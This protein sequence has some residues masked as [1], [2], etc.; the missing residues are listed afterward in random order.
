MGSGI[1]D[2]RFQQDCDV[3][4]SQ[5]SRISQHAAEQDD[6][7]HG[8]HELLRAVDEVHSF[9][10]LRQDPFRGSM[11]NGA[12]CRCICQGL[13]ARG[14]LKCFPSVRFVF[15]S[16]KSQIH[17]LVQEGPGSPWFQCKVKF[18]GISCESGEAMTPHEIPYFEGWVSCNLLIGNNAHLFSI[19]FIKLHAV[20]WIEPFSAVDCVASPRP[21]GDRA[22]WRLQCE[23]ME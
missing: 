8:V 9:Q 20:A 6:S 5:P 12:R 23:N 11:V 7:G 13:S 1:A 15:F 4:V 21:R 16:D 3:H 2:F 17:Q 18:S 10:E 22:E 14:E 19:P